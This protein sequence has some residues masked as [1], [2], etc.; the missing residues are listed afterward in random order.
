VYQHNSNHINNNASGSPVTTE[1]IRQ[2]SAQPPTINAA[3]WAPGAYFYKAKTS[4]GNAL[5]I[6]FILP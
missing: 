3:N 6:K 1:V 5:T 4:N 2:T